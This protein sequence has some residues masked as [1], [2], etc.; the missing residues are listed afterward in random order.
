[1]R[2]LSEIFRKKAPEKPLSYYGSQLVEVTQRQVDWKNGVEQ[3]DY[4]R[5]LV[6][7]ADLVEPPYL[8]NLREGR[9]S[10]DKVVDWNKA[11]IAGY[12]AGFRNK[13]EYEYETRP[14]VIIPHSYDLR[15]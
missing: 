14:Q 2:N 6:I 13:I 5:G 7:G 9:L 10:Y 3:E 4:R 15:N 1:M 8:R 12:Y 11:I